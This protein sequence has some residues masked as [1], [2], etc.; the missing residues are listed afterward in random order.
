M[1]LIKGFY[2][3]RPMLYVG[4][5]SELLINDHHYIQDVYGPHN[6]TAKCFFLTTN[7]TRGSTKTPRKVYA[8]VLKTNTIH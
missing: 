2:C 8:V 4:L 3:N 7:S 5:K 1:G 6:Q